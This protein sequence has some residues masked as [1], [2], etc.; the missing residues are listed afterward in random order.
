M[1]NNKNKPIILSVIAIT[2]FM[3]LLI[4]A[5]YAYFTAQGGEPTSANLNVTTYTTDVATEYNAKIKL[6]YASDYGYAAAPSAWSTD[7]SS[8]ANKSIISAIWVYMV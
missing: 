1:E 7:V 2:T 3:L 5:T 6:M 4:G 8:Y